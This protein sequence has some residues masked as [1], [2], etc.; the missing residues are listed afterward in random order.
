MNG[1]AE[2][3]MERHRREWNENASARHQKAKIDRMETALKSIAAMHDNAPNAAVKRLAKI[4][5]DA[6][7]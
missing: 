5:K 3:C 2:T 6:L 4:A 7:E 1:Q